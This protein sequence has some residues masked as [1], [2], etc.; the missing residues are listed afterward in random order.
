MSAQPQEDS[1]NILDMIPSKLQ[2]EIL[3]IQHNIGKRQEIQQ[4]LL[5]IAAK[6]K[7]DI[8]SIQE[9]SAWKNKTNN[10]YFTI[11]HNMYE[12]ILTANSHIRPRVAIY[13]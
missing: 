4:T 6:R 1:Y 5:K 10:K 2:E 9:P 3:I 11:S 7:A 13:I 8:I 12:L